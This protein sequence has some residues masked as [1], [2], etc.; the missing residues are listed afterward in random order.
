MIFPEEYKHQHDGGLF[1]RLHETQGL[2]LKRSGKFLPK[3]ASHHDQSVPFG[4]ATLNFRMMKSTGDEETVLV[5]GAG[6]HIGGELCPLLR[7]GDHGLVAV[8]LHE[9]FTHDIRACDLTSEPQVTSL[10]ERHAFSSVVHLGGIL[11]SA[12]QSDLLTGAE[13]NL[14]GSLRLLRH[15]IRA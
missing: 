9:D 13:V 10:F 7:N 8:D 3:P 6:G 4:A 5:T 14:G 11:P 1:R 2:F 15:S 12:F